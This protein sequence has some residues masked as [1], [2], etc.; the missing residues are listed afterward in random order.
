MDGRVPGVPDRRRGRPGLVAPGRVDDPCRRPRGPLAGLVTG[1]VVGTGQWLASRGRLRPVPW[2]VATAPLGMGIGLL[3]G[4][5]PSSDSQT[6]LTDVALMGALSGM[7]LGARPDGGAYR[8]APGRRW[9]WAAAMPLLWALGWIVTTWAGIPMVEQFTIFGA[10]G[11]VTFSALSGLLLYRLLPPIAYHRRRHCGR[12]SA[13]H[14]AVGMTGVARHVIFGTG[15][16]GLATCEALLRRGETVRMVNRSG[17]AAVADGVDVV[18]GDAA[19]PAF[20]IDVARG[21]TVVYQTSIR[22]TPA[23]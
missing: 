3:L 15:A 11:A 5:R 9:W 22:R 23:G 6:S 4:A 18:A 1:A 2:I 20:T 17:T 7:V 10:S 12:R 14:A 8:R 13:A 16:I 19:D 21:A